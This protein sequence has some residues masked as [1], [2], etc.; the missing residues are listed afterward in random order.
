MLSQEVNTHMLETNELET[1]EHPR[2]PKCMSKVTK[3]CPGGTYTL[4]PNPNIKYFC[5][6]CFMEW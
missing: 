4:V 3:S 1:T 5:P 2:C 6:V